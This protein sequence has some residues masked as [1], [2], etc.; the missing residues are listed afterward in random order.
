MTSVGRPCWGTTRLGL[1]ELRQLARLKQPLVRVRGQWVE[2]HHDETLRRHHRG[3]EAGR[4]RRTSCPPETVMRSGLGFDQG[5]GE[6][7]VVDVA[8]D[9][10]LGQLL[11]GAEDRTLESTP[12]PEGFAGELRPYQE[13]G[14]GWLAFLGELGLGAC[15]ADDMGLGK[16]AQLLA[17]LVDERARSALTPEDRGGPARSRP[18]RRNDATQ[19]GPDAGACARCPWWGTG[20]ARPPDSHRSWPSTSTTGRAGSRERRSPDTPARWTWSCRPT[21]SRRVTWSCCPA[22]AG[23]AWF[24]TR[25]NRSRTAPPARRRASGRFRPSGASP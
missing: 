19:T 9:G 11:G 15:L 25:H 4:R 6:L 23:A 10:W 1:T 18:A 5:P 8:A 16:T 13:R 20:N 12:T 2:L 22:C 21:A 3:R 7:P 24:S 17:L 14:L